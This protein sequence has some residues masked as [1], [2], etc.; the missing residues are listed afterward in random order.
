MFGVPL[1]EAE[2]GIEADPVGVTDG[3]ADGVEPGGPIGEI[4]DNG[5]LPQSRAGLPSLEVTQSPGK[6]VMAAPPAL[7]KKT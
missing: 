1:G 3:V 5:T 2:G 6:T 7:G 4:N